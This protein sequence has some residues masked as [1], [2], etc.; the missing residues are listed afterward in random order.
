MILV[1]GAFP[2]RSQHL[3]SGPGFSLKLVNYPFVEVVVVAVA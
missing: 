2:R 3:G 1:R